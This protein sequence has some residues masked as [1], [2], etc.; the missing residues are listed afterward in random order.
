M[1]LGE[2]QEFLDFAPDTLGGQVVER[3]AAAERL[4]P[5]LHLEC[6]PGGELDASDTRRLSSANVAGSTA[7][8][9]RRSSKSRRHV[10]RVAID[11]LERIPRDGI[12]GKVA[13][14]RRFVR[15]HVWI[16]GDLEAAVAA[17]SLRLAPR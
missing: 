6:E 5:R 1:I 15:R 17:A 2:E 3:N 4:R 7:R 16:A 13:S 11:V 9:I 8:R 12:D 14:P 10:E